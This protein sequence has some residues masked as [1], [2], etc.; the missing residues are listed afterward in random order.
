MFI[1]LEF[2]AM[3]VQSDGNIAVLR[4]DPSQQVVSDCSQNDAS[5]LWCRRNAGRDPACWFAG[6]RWLSLSLESSSL[7]TRSSSSRFGV[8]FIGTKCEVDL[9]SNDR[10]IVLGKIESLG[11]DCDGLG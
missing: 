11:R 7:L 1:T 10:V 2:A 9:R 4:P 6:I 5:T 8:G 3:Q